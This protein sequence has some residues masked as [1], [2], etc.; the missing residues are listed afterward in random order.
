[1]TSDACSGPEPARLGLFPFYHLRLQ[2]N[3]KM[4]VTRQQGGGGEAQE[5]PCAAPDI[6]Q[7]GPTPNDLPRPQNE[8]QNSLGKEGEATYVQ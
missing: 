7:P 6:L 8:T 1:M 4:A 5:H 2:G 3:V